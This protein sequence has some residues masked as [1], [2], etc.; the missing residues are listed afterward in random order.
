MQCRATSFVSAFGAATV[1][2]AQAH[3]P[4]SSH[5]VAVLLSL[6]RARESAIAQTDLQQ[7]VKSLPREVVRPRSSLT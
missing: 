7:M 4:H 2:S 3:S 5:T 6:I 1:C